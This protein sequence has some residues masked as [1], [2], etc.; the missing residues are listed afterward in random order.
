MQIHRHCEA[1]ADTGRPDPAAAETSSLPTRLSIPR[2][3]MN[4]LLVQLCAPHHARRCVALGTSAAP[5]QMGVDWVR[6]RLKSLSQPG[7]FGEL[8]PH[9]GCPWPHLVA[10]VRP[11]NL[12]SNRLGPIAISEKRQRLALREVT[13]AG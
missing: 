8:E 5:T 12:K 13:G 4:T 7:W 3:A 2:A 6:Q 11:A 9:A 10:A 1:F